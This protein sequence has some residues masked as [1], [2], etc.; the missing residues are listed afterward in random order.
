MFVL[1]SVFA[2]LW[3]VGEAAEPVREVARKIDTNETPTAD[4]THVYAPWVVQSSRQDWPDTCER[5]RFDPARDKVRRVRSARW[6][7]PSTRK[8]Q[9]REMREWLGLVAAEFEP[10]DAKNLASFL[11]ALALRESS[12]NPRAVHVLSEDREA[13]Q[14]AS[15]RVSEGGHAFADARVTVWVEANDGGR[16]VFAWAESAWNYS[17]G[18]FGMPSGLW[19][20]PNGRWGADVPPWALCDR[21]VA[22]TLLVWGARAVLDECV[23]AG[24]PRTYRTLNRRISTGHCRERDPRKERAWTKRARAQGLNP[25]APV[26]F[27][28]QHWPEHGADRDALLRR[29]RSL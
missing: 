11:R 12:Y 19:L 24:H 9:Q 21:R 25:D 5:L 15:R 10:R 28:G 23:R 8:L 3:G 16:L 22:V 27:D 26:R 7:N 18:L 1:L 2:G 14:R 17:R 13:A 6:L 4:T 29:L 20:R